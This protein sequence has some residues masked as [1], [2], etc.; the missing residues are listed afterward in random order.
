MMHFIFV[1]TFLRETQYLIVVKSTVGNCTNFSVKRVK[2]S[3]YEILPDFLT[4]TYLSF[5]LEWN[6]LP[7]STTSSGE[8]WQE[9]HLYINNEYLFLD[10]R[11]SKQ[12]HY[13]F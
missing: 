4:N 7:T 10:D 6:L 12:D 9:N 11:E 8:K 13:V 2:S 3:V 1:M 5:S